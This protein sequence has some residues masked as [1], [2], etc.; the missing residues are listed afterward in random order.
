VVCVVYA[1]VPKILSLLA[2]AHLRARC[3]SP[4]ASASP[5]L[6]QC[7]VR[8][9]L[10]S[11]RKTALV[12]AHDNQLAALALAHDGSKLATASQK[13]TIVR[14]FDCASALPLRELRRGSTSASLYCL[15]FNSTG[16]RLCCS[17]DTS[18]PVLQRASNYCV[19]LFQA[20]ST[21]S[22][23]TMAVRLLH[24]LHPA[25]SRTPR[26]RWACS[27][28]CSPNIFLRNGRLRSGSAIVQKP[29]SRFRPWDRTAST[30]CLPRAPSPSFH[31]TLRQVS[32]HAVCRNMPASSCV[33]CKRAVSSL[34]R[35]GRQHS[36][37]VQL[38]HRCGQGRLARQAVQQPKAVRDGK[39]LLAGALLIFDYLLMPSIADR[40]PRPAISQQTVVKFIIGTAVEACTQQNLTNK[41]NLGD[42]SCDKRLRWS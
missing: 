21:Y 29:S 32:P 34:T 28:A 26:R 8:I 11:Q 27:R 9:E 6:T 13:G 25:L 5:F 42:K 35:C 17:S 31:L 7:Q 18:E 30:C 1:P 3:A 14:I 37:D 16:N 33:R 39:L 22:R 23:W 12:A 41:P 15:S 20:P 24:L 2:P 19:N 4:S 10:L 38:A 40:L 36:R